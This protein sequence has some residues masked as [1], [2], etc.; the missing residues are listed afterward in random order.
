MAGPLQRVR[1]GDAITAEWAN[2][3]VDAVES[4]QRLS[5]A[6]PLQLSQDGAGR[7]L[8]LAPGLR[9]EIFEL[10]DDIAAGSSADAKILW[11]DGT[12]WSDAAT[13]NII[14]HDA[15]GTFDGVAGERGIAFFHR[16]AKPAGQ[17]V[18]LQLEC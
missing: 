8:S 1:R 14:V 11:F 2:A 3:L 7:R 4:L 15:I 10:I 5:V 16:Q 9:I 17:W 18:I 12:A 6:A 13:H